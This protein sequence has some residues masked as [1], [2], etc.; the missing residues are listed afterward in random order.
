MG[1]PKVVYGDGQVEM[2]VSVDAVIISGH[3][4]QVLSVSH[5]AFREMVIGFERWHEMRE[6][7]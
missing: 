4:G 6:D 3:D 1:V 7:Q 5:A 2:A